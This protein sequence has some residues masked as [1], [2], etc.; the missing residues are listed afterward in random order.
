MKHVILHLSV[1]T[2]VLVS[3]KESKTKENI[4]RL[5]T[6]WQGKEIVFLGYPV[7]TRYAADTVESSYY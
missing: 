7:F 5:V 3:C 2:L 4:A 6:E 1:L